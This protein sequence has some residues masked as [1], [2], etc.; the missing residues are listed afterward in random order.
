MAIPVSYIAR[1]LF[2]RRL[3]T[4]LTAGGMALVVYVFATVLMLAAGLEKT[5]VDARLDFGLRGTPDDDDVVVLAGRHER[6]LQSRREHQHRREHVD[7]E[8]HPARG[9]DR[10]EPSRREIACDVGKW[11]G[12]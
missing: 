8:R 3:T 7:D 6:R 4:A 1:N 5:P 2:A 11:N 10:R 9:K 12:H